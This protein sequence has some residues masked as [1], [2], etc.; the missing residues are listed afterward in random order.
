MKKLTKK[1]FKKPLTNV[2]PCGTMNTTKERKRDTTMKK[3]ICIIL[4][5]AILCSVC[6]FRLGHNHARKTAQL[7]NV[8]DYGYTIQYGE[9]AHAFFDRYEFAN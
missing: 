8:N 5:T 6:S 3:T 7:V 1:I 4:A 9:G 2:Q